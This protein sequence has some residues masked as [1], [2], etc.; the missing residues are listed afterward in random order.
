MKNRIISILLA[1]VLVLSLA[2][3][4]GQTPNQQGPGGTVEQ[5]EIADVERDFD[6]FSYSG[7]N[8]LD[9]GMEPF[10]SPVTIQIPVFDRARDDV[11]DVTNN[12]YTRWIQENFGDN[13]NVTVEFVPINRADT[14]TAYNLLLS[15]G[16]WPTIF[17]EYDWPKVTEWYNDGALRKFDL[18]RFAAVA[19]TWFE[20]AG[21]K[22]MFDMF[23]LGGEYIFA[24]TL[25]PFWLADT[26]ITF[27]RKDCFMDLGFTN[28]KPIVNL[29][30]FSVSF[31]GVNNAAYANSEWPRVEE[32]WAMYSCFGIAA[33]PSRGMYYHLKK[34]NN[35][36][37]RGL[38][39]P[40]FELDHWDDIFW[41][42]NPQ[43]EADFVN[44]E[45]FSFSNF[46]HGD[47]PA[48]TAFYSNFPDAELGIMY[49]NTVANP[50]ADAWGGQTVAQDRAANPAGFFI[51][52]SSRATDDE[53]LAAWLYMEWMAQ[54]DVLEYMQWGPE[55]KTWNY[56][57][58]GN[59][60]MIHWEKQGDYWMGFGSNKDYWAIV[61]EIR[62]TALG[63][64]E[65][66]VRGNT[67]KGIPQDFTRELLDVLAMNKAKANSGLLYIDPY[68]TV[69]IPS[70]W[71]Y[72]ST[73]EPL[74]VE[75]ATSL[76]KT[77]PGNFDVLYAELA[78]QYLNAGYR[79]VINERLAAFRAG[80]S[81]RIM[82][83]AGGRAPFVQPDWVRVTGGRRY[84]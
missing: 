46:V 30:P 36:F 75:F 11:P 65:V 7:V 57:F 58:A 70:F 51:G 29:R 3:C 67:P 17:M 47:M 37:N 8:P 44:G 19:P 66:M 31:R 16:N 68:F 64:V 15:A 60:T 32:E 9:Y 41:H 48:L 21:G 79:P 76:V 25:R 80:N 13:L 39:K 4:A 5:T 59:R 43:W 14:M 63:G 61:E 82:D 62:Q 78:E 35:E 6:R 12:H 22:D 54:Y 26:L 23:A 73:L 27:Y 50:W 24:P 33:L 72:Q 28:G 42:G 40:D 77:S 34:L 56:D 53:L 20:M 10:A 52:F 45:A 71:E 55:G 38:I 1:A 69:D 74:F 84:E 49:S 2:A 83:V 81:T 18:G